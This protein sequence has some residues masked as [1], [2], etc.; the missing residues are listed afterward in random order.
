MGCASFPGAMPLGLHRSRCGPEP[1]T[2]PWGRQPGVPLT[3]PGWLLGTGRGNAGL[4]L[5]KRPVPLLALPTEPSPPK[6]L[7]NGERVS[8]FL[9]SIY[10]YMRLVALISRMAPASIHAGSW[11]RRDL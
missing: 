4:S 5:Q 8:Y 2:H 9:K 7:T 10:E 3:L 1:S 6:S 11:V